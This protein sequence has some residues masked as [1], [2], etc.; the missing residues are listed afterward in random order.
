MSVCECLFTCG[1]G[2]SRSVR[3]ELVWWGRVKISGHS[4]FSVLS[5]SVPASLAVINCEHEGRNNQQVSNI[6]RFQDPKIDLVPCIRIDLILIKYFC[7]NVKGSWFILKSL[8]SSQRSQRS[9]IISSVLLRD[10]AMF[11]PAG[12]VSVSLSGH[13]WH[14]IYC[15][16]FIKTRNLYIMFWVKKRNIRSD[17][18]LDK[19]A[20]LPGKSLWLGQRQ[21]RTIYGEIKTS[22]RGLSDGV[23]SDIWVDNEFLNV[24]RWYL[25]FFPASCWPLVVVAPGCVCTGQWHW[26]LMLSYR[27]MGRVLPSRLMLS[28]SSRGQI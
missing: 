16:Y 19:L 26:D 8:K 27:Y 4:Q 14:W 9:D 22:I 3:A 1:A 13:M 17:L 11:T 15:K 12:S 23:D 10:S 21:M 28:V 20:K 6:S 25:L 5:L 7:L 18:S 24:E 2:S